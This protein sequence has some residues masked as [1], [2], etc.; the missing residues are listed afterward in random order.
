MGKVIRMKRKNTLRR[1]YLKKNTL[2]RKNTLRKNNSIRRKVTRNY[3]KNRKRYT[4]NKRMKGGVVTDE[5]VRE[6]MEIILKIIN[7]EEDKRKKNQYNFYLKT[8]EGQVFL[9]NYIHK[10][11]LY[12]ISVAAHSAMSYHKVYFPVLLE[13]QIKKNCTTL[14]NI[15]CLKRS[16]FCKWDPDEASTEF[17]AGSCNSR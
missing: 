16:I 10:Y 14:P 6:Q 11:Y 3:S 4:K 13:E 9:N 15:E 12:A 2:R 17:G 8:P 1:K 7:K 5:Y